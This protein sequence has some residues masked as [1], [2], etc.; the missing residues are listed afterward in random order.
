MKKHKPASGIIYNTA[1][2]FDATAKPSSKPANATLF[3]P[4]SAVPP[5]DTA[6]AARARAVAVI[7]GKACADE[8]IACGIRAKAPADIKPAAVE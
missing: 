2:Y 8:I 3:H 6:S 4:R 7:S 5:A 1:W